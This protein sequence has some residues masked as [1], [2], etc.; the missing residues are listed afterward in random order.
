MPTY[1]SD[2]ETVAYVWLNAEPLIL[3]SFSSLN[4]REDP[5]VPDAPFFTK[6][7]YDKYSLSPN[8]RELWE[9]LQS[10]VQN[11][12]QDHGTSEASSSSSSKKDAAAFKGNSCISKSESCS[13]SCDGDD[14]CADIDV[15]GATECKDTKKSRVKLHQIKNEAG[16]VY[17]EPRL[18]FPCLSSLSVKDQKTYLGFLMSKKASDPPQNLQARVNSEVMQFMRYLQDVAKICADDYNFITPG[19]MQYSEEFFGGCLEHIRTFPELYQI[20]EMTSLTGGTFNPGLKLTFEKQLLI[21]G[22]VDITDHTMVPAD[23]QLASD[24]QSVSSQNPP[25]KK[26]KDMHATISGDVNASSLCARYEPHVCLT[27][28]ALVKLLDNHGPD[29]AEQWE[30]PVWIKSNPGE[31]SKQK[32]TVY[33]DSPLLKTEM[34]MKEGAMSSMRRV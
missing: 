25:A 13:E 11:I 21:M 5:P 28:D 27:R 16:A 34:T 18:P 12:K 22:N 6:D 17:P 15:Q 3:F 24:Y 31:G 29:F 14:P 9:F 30:L 4:V 2:R 10:P 23:A 7:L 20:Y 8:I 32:K 19:A 1:K 33:I 26:A